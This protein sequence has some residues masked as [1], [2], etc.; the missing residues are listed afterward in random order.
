MSLL[1]PWS[2]RLIGSARSDLCPFF[3]LALALVPL[4]PFDPL[5]ADM[6]GEVGHVQFDGFHEDKQ[7]ASAIASPLSP[8]S[9]GSRLMTGIS[10]MTGAS[11]V[12]DQNSA[13]DAGGNA[14]KAAVNVGV[15]NMDSDSEEGEGTGDK[16]AILQSPVKTAPRK[17]SLIAFQKC[18]RLARFLC[19]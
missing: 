9:P 17:L 4:V 13:A 10:V 12:Q 3:T 5:Q 6:Q 18:R 8:S 11:S 7:P 15:E 14:E 19:I 16:D 1:P 2:A